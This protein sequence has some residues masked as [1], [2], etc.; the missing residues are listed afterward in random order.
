MVSHHS[1]VPAF[2]PFPPRQIRDGISSEEWTSCVEAWAILAQ[3]YLSLPPADFKKALDSSGSLVAFLTSFMGAAPLAHGGDVKYNEAASNEALRRDMFL[4]VHRYISEGNHVSAKIVSWEF[5]GDFSR[6]YRTSGASL[7]DLLAKIWVVRRA[8]F[9][10]SLQSLKG[11]LTATLETSSLKDESQ[12]PLAKQIIPLVHAFP[13]AGAFFMTGS[14]LLDALVGFYAHASKHT[15][16]RLVM[17]TYLA[18]SALMQGQKQNHSLLF[19]HLYSLKASAEVEPKGHSSLLADLVTNTPLLEKIKKTITGSDRVRAQTLTASLE[20]FR[21]SRQARPKRHIRRKIVKGKGKAE[22]EYGHAAFGSIHVHRMSLVTQVQD[23]FPDLGSAFI[24]KLLDEYKDD[25]EQVTAHLLDDS[26][27]S[28]LQTLDHTETLPTHAPT[29]NDLVPNLAPRATP[30][31]SPPPEIVPSHRRNIH[32]DDEFDRLV[33]DASRLHMGRK[34]A[35]LTADRLLSMAEAR[36]NKAAIMSALAAFD[37]D[38]DEYDDTYDIADVG[39]TVD[40]ARPGGTHD[41]ADAAIDD[42]R[43]VNEEALFQA[44]RASPELFERDAATRRGQPRKALRSETGLTDEAIEGWGI[45]MRRD[46]RRM[47]RLEARFATFAGQQTELGA[48]AWRGNA[49]DTTED[50]EDGHHGIG[51]HRG[52]TRGMGRGDPRGGGAGR[53]RGGNV[54]GSA[55]DKG[56]QASRQRKEENKGSR[57]N[58]NRR[59]QR[60]RKMA[61]GGFPG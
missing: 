5:L 53:G 20:K 56:T 1:V 27:P 25:A 6:V 29:S 31:S 14:D 2:L 52:G 55:D 36:P 9:E 40:S 50:E 47:R 61:R 44:L 3:V 17:F 46:P 48:S 16:S 19:D 58:H 8:Q 35:S 10:L 32:D 43:D 7:H 60:A 15:Q 21:S 41:E 45:M 13:T 30:P 49:E 18:L 24:A 23:L 37:A 26:L 39:G 12:L 4:L 22:D 33:V 42:M 28:H 57:A 34:N 11:Q 51:G 54:A 59:D 38:D